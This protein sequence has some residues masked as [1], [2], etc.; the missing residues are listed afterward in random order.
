MGRLPRNTSLL[1]KV[2]CNNG[3]RVDWGRIWCCVVMCAAL[4]I[5]GFT[6]LV[7][8]AISTT[9]LQFVYSDLHLALLNAAQQIG[10]LDQVVEETLLLH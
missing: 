8:F 7:L 2:L 4:N 3:R 6:I 5:M 1:V 10:F 9:L